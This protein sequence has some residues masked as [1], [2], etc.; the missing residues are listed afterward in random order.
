MTCLTVKGEEL[1]FAENKKHT[2]ETSGLL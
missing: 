2:T 1:G